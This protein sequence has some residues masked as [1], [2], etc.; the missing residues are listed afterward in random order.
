MTT[1]AYRALEAALIAAATWLVYAPAFHGGWFWDDPS[2][3]TN[4]LALRS[5]AGLGRIW[6]A[7]DSPDYYPLKMSLQWVQ[8]HLW[9]D[10][11]TGYHLT[12][13][14]LHLLSA[15]LIWWLLSKLGVRLAWIGG[16]LFAVHPLAVESVAWISELK[17]VLSLP[18]L[19]LAFGAWI[20]WDRKRGTGFQPVIDQDTGRMPVLH[21][22]KSH[23]SAFWYLLALLFFLASM[24]CKSSVVMFPVVLLLYAWWRRGR[25]AWSDLR[26]TAPFFAVALILGLV[27]Y[28]FQENV[29]SKDLVIGQ[30]GFLP[31][32]AVAGMAIMFYAWKFV[33][34]VDLMPIYPRWA[35]NPPALWQFWPWPLIGAVIFV[36][37]RL[38]GSEGSGGMKRGRGGAPRPEATGCRFYLGRPVALGLGWFLINL[39]P[40]LGFVPMSFLRIS[41]VADHFAYLPMVGL[42]GVAAAGLSLAFD[43]VAQASSPAVSTTAGGTPALLWPVFVT[44]VLLA[45][46]AGLARQQAAIF[47]SEQAAW[48]HT[49]ARNPE[50]WLAHNNLSNILL[51]EGKVGEAQ[52]EVEWALRI[53]PDFAEAHNNLG[54][55]LLQ[56]GQ[57]EAARPQFEAA[58]KFRKNYAEAY[59]G[60]GNYCLKSDRPEMALAWY[61]AA[62][63]LKPD[64]TDCRDNRAAALESLGRVNEAIVEYRKVLEVKPGFAAAHYN[65]GIALAK[66]GEFPGAVEQ[67][68]LALQIDPTLVQAYNNLANALVA[69]RRTREAIAD[70]EQAL[71]IN[72][73][74]FEVHINLGNALYNLHQVPAA[75]AQ[76]HE[77]LRLG[78]GY[79]PG[80]NNLGIALQ[81]T[82]RV[83]EARAAFEQALRLNPDY[84]TASQNLDRLNRGR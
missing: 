80:W 6:F 12:N 76:F 55:I 9:Q 18:L 66:A 69:M 20:E 31:R 63:K 14:G 81:A 79:A 25:V 68:S 51:N 50:A 24:L 77:A 56:I 3:I 82:G 28:W 83:A 71:R 53:K 49:L 41:W 10:N 4:N 73:N 61:E 45:V 59:N 23:P 15:Y 46:L 16:L 48:V 35:V 38:S 47:Q 60:M 78:P 37:W 2:E 33:W 54:N 29:A 39:V 8:W 62:L 43:K 22:F 67:Y 30:G 64:Y 65:L 84:E 70:Y 26:A 75:I 72:P 13:V 40:V 32:L 11:L 21:Q 1:K 74:F 19:L 58:I 52:K 27:T 34:P 7:P 57:V 5:R 17:N 42:V 44:A 36:I